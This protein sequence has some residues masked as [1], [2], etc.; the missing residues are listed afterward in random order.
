MKSKIKATYMIMLHKYIK[1]PIYHI[2]QPKN[3]CNVCTNIVYHFWENTNNTVGYANKIVLDA[4][5]F[6]TNNANLKQRN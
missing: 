4:K 5:I 2:C 1:D 3:Y 6:I